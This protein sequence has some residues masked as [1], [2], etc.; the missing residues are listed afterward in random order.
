M[1]NALDLIDAAIA[2]LEAKLN[3]APGQSCRSSNITTGPLLTAAAAASKEKTSP[4]ETKN[5]VTEKP[6]DTKKS[7]SKQ[8][9]NTST[10]NKAKEKTQQKNE[11]QPDICKLEFKVGK[12]I[13]AWVHPEA[14]K[15][16]CEEIDVGEETPR[17]IASGL[18]KHYTL[19]EMQG[20]RVV[21][22]SNLKPKKL[23][24]FASFGMVLCAAGSCEN[25]DEKVEFVEPPEGAVIG[26]VI[27]YQGLPY[28][29]P[30]SGAQVEKKKI[31][32][33]CAEGM[34]TT[35]E[36]LAAWNG[37]LFMTSAGPCTCATLGNCAMR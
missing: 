9:T 1:S 29:Q 14:D 18:R 25:N 36:R 4:H 24:G 23:A 26:E 7:S 37:H 15:L 11:D 13:K 6:K 8:S 3:L 22:V 30:W 12:I 33:A 35:E 27:T 17:L 16:Y 5:T 34:R 32:Q 28:P 10:T 2:D 21:V 20:R 19:E 31:F